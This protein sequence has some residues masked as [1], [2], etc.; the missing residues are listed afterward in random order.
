[1]YTVKRSGIHAV[2]RRY[3]GKG[4]TGSPPKGAPGVRGNHQPTQLWILREERGENEERKWK[5]GAA[6]RAVVDETERMTCKENGT[7][8]EPQS[9]FWNETTVAE[10]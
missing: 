10:R 6:F 2:P 7:K 9:F 8:C 5:A 4:K 1:V 3:R